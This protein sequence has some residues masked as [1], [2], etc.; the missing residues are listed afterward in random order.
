MESDSVGSADVNSDTPENDIPETDPVF[1]SRRARSGARDPA[2]LTRLRD[3]GRA[4]VDGAG[5][6][7]GVGVQGAPAEVYASAAEDAAAA[8]GATSSGVAQTSRDAAAR[9]GMLVK[10]FAEKVNPGLHDLAA[11]REGFGVWKEKFVREMHSS[12]LEAQANAR[13]I[14]L[15]TRSDMMIKYFSE[16]VAPGVHDVAMKKERFGVW[17]EKFM[18][19]IH[20]LQ[21]EAQDRARELHSK[22]RSNMMIKYFSERVA[23][24]VQDVTMKKEGF[25]VWKEKFMHEIHSAQLEAQERARKLHTKTV[26]RGDAMVKYF[27]EKVTPAVHDVAMKKEAFGWWKDEFVEARFRKR[28]DAKT[29]VLLNEIRKMREEHAIKVVNEKKDAIQASLKHHAED[30]NATLKA[31]LKTRG[32]MLVKYFSEKVSPAVHDIAVKRDGFALWKD[33]C[34]EENIIEYEELLRNHPCHPALLLEDGPRIQSEEQVEKL[35]EQVKQFEE[36][37]KQFEEQLEEQLEAQIA[38]DAAERTIIHAKSRSDMIVKYFSEEVAPAVHQVACKKQA[39][40][41]WK[42]DFNVF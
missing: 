33:Q 28:E 19:E 9:S 2:P 8:K 42:A 32:D 27:S 16:R 22:T 36:Q 31:T 21:L 34:I 35:E 4:G 11:R 12:R 20:F 14:H 1:Y 6:G 40:G 18:H 25:G 39:F 7:Q 37:V 29:S 17:K 15:K 23:P 24:G 5:N 38:A 3:D 26:T 13:K 41:E 30:M 10:C